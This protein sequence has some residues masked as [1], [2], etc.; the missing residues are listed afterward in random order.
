[1]IDDGCTKFIR[2]FKAVYEGEL[3]IDLNH[4]AETRFV[5]L[6]SL[7]EL[8]LGGDALTPTFC[9]IVNALLNRRSA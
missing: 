5:T 2:V 1:M 3:R 9:H 7:L 6:Q 4:I 8:P